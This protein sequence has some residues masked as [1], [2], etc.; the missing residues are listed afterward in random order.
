MNGNSQPLSVLSGKLLHKF[1]QFLEKNLKKLILLAFVIVVAVAAFVILGQLA[2]AKAREA[3]NALLTA[4]NIDE[5]RKVSSDFPESSAAGSATALLAGQLWDEG[6]EDE[7]IQALTELTSGSNQAEV[8]SHARFALA[9]MLLKK[10]RTDEAKAT[11]EALLADDTAK[12]LHPLSLIAL[13]DIAKSAGDDDLARDYYNQKIDDYPS[14]ADQG[15]AVTRLNLVGV[16]DAQRV[17]PPP[18]V[19]APESATPEAGISP[20]I[21]APTPIQVQPTSTPTPSAAIGVTS[22]EESTAITDEK[23][24]FETPILSEKIEQQENSEVPNGNTSNTEEDSIQSA[25]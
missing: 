6:K 3:G 19:T 11:Y 7:A 4:E 22:S 23:P 10:E 5:L 21:S 9:S 12:H 15:L 25:E 20:N 14:Y 1:D 18:P 8:S 2:D 16:D 17:S 24:L 13:G